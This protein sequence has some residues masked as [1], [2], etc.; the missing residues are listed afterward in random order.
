MVMVN[1][2][3]RGWGKMSKC[4]IG[5]DELYTAGDGNLNMSY[6]YSVDLAIVRESSLMSGVNHSSKQR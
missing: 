1:H 4:E 6:S 3:F 5:S 2:G